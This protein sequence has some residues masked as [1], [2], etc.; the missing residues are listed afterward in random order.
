MNRAGRDVRSE[1]IHPGAPI[2]RPK[3]RLDNREV[4]CTQLF[5]GTYLIAVFL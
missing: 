2:D 4:D 5:P 3:N 1:P